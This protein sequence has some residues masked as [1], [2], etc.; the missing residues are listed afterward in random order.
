MLDVTEVNNRPGWGDHVLLIP[1]HCDPTVN[2]HDH[3]ICVR[4]LHTPGAVVEDIWPV[5]ARGALN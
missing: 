5:A 2:L 3:Y 4:G 1:G